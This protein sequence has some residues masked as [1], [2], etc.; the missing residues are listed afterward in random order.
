MGD[1]NV[2]SDA[3]FPKRMD[4]KG[5]FVPMEK[6]EPGR[7]VFIN[8]KCQHSEGE[9]RPLTDESE[10]LEVLADAIAQRKAGLTGNPVSISTGN[11]FTKS[12]AHKRANPVTTHVPAPMPD[13]PGSTLPKEDLTGL[14]EETR[15]AVQHRMATP[16]VLGKLLPR[17]VPAEAATED[18]LPGAPAPVAR[19]VPEE[20]KLEAVLDALGVNPTKVPPTGEPNV[21]GTGGH[22]FSGEELSPED[23]ELARAFLADQEVAGEPSS[24]QQELAD[25]FPAIFGDGAAAPPEA[26]PDPEPDPAPEPTEA[27][28]AATQKAAPKAT[29]AAPKKKTA[30]KKAAP[31]KATAAKKTTKKPAR[32]TPPGMTPAGGG[33]IKKRK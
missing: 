3:R 32:R 8:A 6:P 2:A 22:E 29:G 15:L 1:D 26:D 11:S 19:S 12:A 16:A 31:K 30:K 24:D 21:S 7:Q 10:G 17:E 9:P 27:T 5:L 28:I 23:Q 4:P 25:K 18:A 13:I 33:T 14:N 20:G